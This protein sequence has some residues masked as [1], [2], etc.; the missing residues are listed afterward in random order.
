MHTPPLHLT[1]PQ[2]LVREEKAD[3]SNE[4]IKPLLMRGF[5]E[6]RE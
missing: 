5:R 3:L 4:A 2:F 1:L 6:G